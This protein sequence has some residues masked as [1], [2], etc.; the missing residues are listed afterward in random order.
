MSRP[1]SGFPCDELQ[2]EPESDAQARRCHLERVGAGADV[3]L[4]RPRQPQPL[5]VERGRL[6]PGYHADLTL[7]DAATVEDTATYDDPKQTPTGV[8]L[9]IVN[10]RVAWRNGQHQNA[11]SGQMLRYRREAYA[12][13]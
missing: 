7:F 2:V 1:G 5:G 9:V 10:G 13:D 12:Q 11:A 8:P 3:P 4:E 6:E